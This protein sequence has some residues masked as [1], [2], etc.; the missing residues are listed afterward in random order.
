VVVPFSGMLA[1]LEWL[2]IG[3]RMSW[4]PYLLG[5]IC[6]D[7]DEKGKTSFG[8]PITQRDV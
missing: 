5:Y 3:R 1:L 6:I 4:L 8:G 2:T 7:R